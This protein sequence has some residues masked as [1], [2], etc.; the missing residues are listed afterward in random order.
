MSK[1]G[2]EAKYFGKSLPVCDI[3]K[4]DYYELVTAIYDARLG[5][6]YCTWA[7]VCEECYN[8]F[9]VGLGTGFGQKL[10]LVNTKE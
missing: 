10:T 6:P 8:N 7:Y 5:I 2:T 9:G 4:L 3:H 1:Q